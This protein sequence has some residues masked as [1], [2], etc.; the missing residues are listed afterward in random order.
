[1]SIKGF[2]SNQKLP[3]G[4]GVTSEHVT[5]QPTDEFRNVLDTTARFAFRVGGDTPRVAAANTGNIDGFTWVYDTNTPARRGDFVRFE[6]G[7]AQFKEIAIIKVETNRFLLGAF[8]SPPPAPNDTFFIMRYAT[9]RVDQDGTQLVSIAPSPTSF[10]LNGTTTN[11]Q[12]DTNTPANSKPLP[13][14]VLDSAGLVPDFATQATLLTRATEATALSIKSDTAAIAAVDFATETTLAAAAANIALIQGKDF[15]TQ[16]TLLTRATE[17][18]ALAIKADTAAIAAKDFATETTLAAAA[19]N[20]ALIQ[21][22]DFATQT[23]LLTRATE[24]TALAIKADTA[25]IAAKDFATEATL[26]AVDTKLNNVIKN[27]GSHNFLGAGGKIQGGAWKPINVNS[28]GDVFVVEQGRTAVDTARHSYSSTP[29]NTTNWQQLIASTSGA[30]RRVEIFDSSG[31]TLE[32]GV[33]AP[34]SEVRQILIFPGGNGV[35]PLTIAS[36]A[37][38]SVRA[39]SATANEGEISINFYS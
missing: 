26:T 10:V 35:V 38:V 34:G 1:M 16:T 14:K 31:Q 30:I 15:A 36:G 2:P 11:V 32:L 13:V 9:Q 7:A 22:K 17:A 3:L 37:R 23:T 19:A 12:E 6:T 24:A 21:G 39:V 5:V 18:T 4:S 20:I 29:V 27:D 28:D 8:V 33:G 25:T